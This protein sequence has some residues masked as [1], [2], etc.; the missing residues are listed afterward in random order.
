MKIA[1]LGGGN[2]FWKMAEITLLKLLKGGGGSLHDHLR[3]LR[4]LTTNTQQLEILV[5]TLQQI[6]KIAA[7]S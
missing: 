6:K 3:L 2:A 1:F 7:Y 5:K 4:L